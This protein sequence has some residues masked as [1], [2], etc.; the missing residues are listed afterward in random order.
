MERRLLTLLFAKKREYFKSINFK[1]EEKSQPITVVFI[2]KWK[3]DR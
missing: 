1:E 3:E 2:T